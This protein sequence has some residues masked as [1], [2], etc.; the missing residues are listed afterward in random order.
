MNKVAIFTVLLECT[1]VVRPVLKSCQVC[2]ESEGITACRFVKNCSDGIE[3][4]E[5]KNPKTETQKSGE[6]DE[7]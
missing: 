3:P 6:E 4:K 1:L 5:P 7:E 2:C